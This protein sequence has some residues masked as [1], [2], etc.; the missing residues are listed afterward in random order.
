MSDIPRERSAPMYKVWNVLEVIALAIWVGGIAAT[1]LVGA[2]AFRSGSLDRESAGAFMAEVFRHFRVVE[3]GAAAL[4]LA[5]ALFTRRRSLPRVGLALAMAILLGLNFFTAHRMREIR[6]AA[7]GNSDRL[8]ASDPRRAEFRR[9][10]GLYQ[11]GE[12]V[13]LASGLVLLGTTVT[14]RE[15]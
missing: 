7:G 1:G 6:T 14:R 4:V 2:L 10:H 13:L 5:A 12:A 9:L 3:A 11:G 8:L 15:A